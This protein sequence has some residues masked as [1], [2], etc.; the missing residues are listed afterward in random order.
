MRTPYAL[1]FL[2]LGTLVSLSL[3]AQEIEKPVTADLGVIN[4]IDVTKT[5]VTEEKLNNVPKREIK[6]ERIAEAGGLPLPKP[7]PKLLEQKYA[8]K[9]RLRIPR[10]GSNYA[11]MLRQDAEMTT[12][13][14]ID[15]RYLIAANTYGSNKQK[16]LAD[17]LPAMINA[18]PKEDFPA[19]EEREFFASSKSL[20][21]FVSYYDEAI[22]DG[23]GE[24]FWSFQVL[25]TNP[26]EAE[27]RCKALIY[28]FDQGSCRPIRLAILKK[29]E[30]VCVQLREQRK[31]AE[32]LLQMINSVQNAL[33]VFADFTPD[34]LSNLRVQQLQLEVELAG[35]KARIATCDRLLAQANLKLERRNQIEDVKVSAEIEFSGFEAR[36]TKSNEFIAK[37][38][39][40][41]ELLENLAKLEAEQ[42]KA[43]STLR[44]LEGQIH[45]I[46]EAI[47]AFA[48]LPLVDNKIVIQPIEWTQ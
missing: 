37:V 47:K 21:D 19:R 12:L 42:K 43:R 20:L 30:P 11:T 18:L 48:P 4:D 10:S 25:A 41:V 36:L 45:F 35:V 1:F 5:D 23:S 44:G 17:S 8:G 34:M 38:K 26:E 31:G 9:F 24:R 14:L 29:R 15:Q 22:D 32:A 46:D 39:Q 40:K 3:S 16:T 13:G 7:D 6:V 28:T 27:R 2:T 33:K